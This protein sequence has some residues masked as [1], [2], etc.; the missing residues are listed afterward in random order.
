MQQQTLAEVPE[1]GLD[2]SGQNMEER[3]AV[4]LELAKAERKLEM[5]LEDVKAQRSHVK[6]LR[7][8]L[9]GL[10]KALLEH[11][12]KRGAKRLFSKSDT[13]ALA[14][15]AAAVAK[16]KP[17]ADVASEAKAGGADVVEEVHG[18]LAVALS[19]DGK[20]FRIERLAYTNEPFVK[21]MVAGR[22]SKFSRK[23]DALASA[24]ESA[25]AKLWKKREKEPEAVKAIDA[26][27]TARRKLE[28]YEN[29][30]DWTP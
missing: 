20:T 22:D 3:K 19:S 29:S 7:M 28:G 5:Q 25:I 4:L 26:M 23:E 14:T 16:G 11:D 18:G 2:A 12:A 9:E 27:Q 21:L 15:A 30:P 8:E 10:D 13:P 17:S 24:L 1:G 6:R